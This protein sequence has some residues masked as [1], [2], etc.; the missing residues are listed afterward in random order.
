MAFTSAKKNHGKDINW[1]SL[2]RDVSWVRNMAAEQKKVA[3]DNNSNLI[4]DD[5]CPVCD[6]KNT[7]YFIEI[8]GYTYRQCQDDGHIFLANKPA[9]QAIADLYTSEEKQSAQH[10]VYMNADL[11]EKRAQMIGYPKVEFVDKFVEKAERKAG[12]PYWLDIGCGTGE[13]LTAAMKNGCRVRGI[14]SDSNEVDF[15]RKKGIDVV[16]EYVSSN[17]N[18]KIFIDVD[19]VS[20]INIVEHILNPKEFL[21]NIISCMQSGCIIVTEVPRHPSLSS[22]VNV[23]QPG[24][25]YRH[26]CSPD[27]M[28]IFT[29]NSLEIILNGLGCSAKA[30]WYFGQDIYNYFV[31]SIAQAK[32]KID[33]N[34]ID[35]IY[36]LIP[37]LQHTIDEEGYSDTLFVVAVKG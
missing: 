12:S 5:R 8:Y 6:T 34:F 4:Y 2:N 9:P 1:D 31:T 14:E 36:K 13:L 7:K 21:S 29:D 25:A 20:C 23:T 22:F 3:D 30:V 24:V 18:K 19:V 17:M 11:F 33:S 10:I 37:K 32:N 26:I 27:H 15:A 28:H 16:E 35:A